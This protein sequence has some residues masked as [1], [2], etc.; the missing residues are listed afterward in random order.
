M[1]KLLKL[2][3]DEGGA[4]SIELGLVTALIAAVILVAMTTIGLRLFTAIYSAD[5]E[6]PQ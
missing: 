2:L 6:P 5:T 3:K 4:I 1:K